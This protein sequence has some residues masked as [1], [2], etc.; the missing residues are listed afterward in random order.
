MK[1]EKKIK[2]EKKKTK[3]DV[4]SQQSVIK[5]EKKLSSLIREVE[6]L[7]AALEEFRGRNILLL[8]RLDNE[9]KKQNLLIESK[10]RQ[11]TI[12]LINKLLP[13]I[14]SFQRAF[15]E[16]R[17]LL[18]QKDNLITLF[19]D[20]SRAFAFFDDFF[21]GFDLVMRNIISVFEEEGMKE[22]PAQPGMRPKLG[23]HEVIL[24]EDFSDSAKE[25]T[26]AKVLSK[27]YTIKDEVIRPARV[28]IFG[29]SRSKPKA[30]D[31]KFKGEE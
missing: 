12:E 8:A 10:K 17:V 1:S 20:S 4:L 23:F 19:R 31:P 16:K 21:L 11:R 27:G 5:N 7:T 3:T 14:D 6:K 29:K 26:I 22:I 25:G 24:L 2:E 28:V 30:A 9:L 13:S 18:S 15:E